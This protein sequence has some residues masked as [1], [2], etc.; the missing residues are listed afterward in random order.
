[1]TG[2]PKPT[3]LKVFEGNRGKRPLPEDEPQPEAIM[4]EC[5]DWLSKKAKEVFAR[6]APKFYKVGLLTEIDG[7][8]FGAMCQ[9]IAYLEEVVKKLENEELIIEK[10]IGRGENKKTETKVNPLQVEFRLLTNLVRAY[11]SEFG[12]TP[13]G[14][15]PLSVGMDKDRDGE[16][17]LSR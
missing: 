10:E 15:A 17:L 13:R 5:P 7:D 12:G 6:E 1:M 9:S 8:Q 16:D 3:A 11:A 14:R 4:P 2:R